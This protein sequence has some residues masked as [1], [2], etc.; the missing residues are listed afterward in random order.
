MHG[1]RKDMPLL[2]VS[3]GIEVSSDGLPT[4]IS[5]AHSQVEPAPMRPVVTSTALLSYVLYNAQDTATDSLMEKRRA[6]QRSKESVATGRQQVPSSG[7]GSTSTEEL[8]DLEGSAASRRRRWQICAA[9]GCRPTTRSR[10]T[11]AC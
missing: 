1:G 3:C 5:T 9:V 6:V 11:D 4:P 10:S 2:C 8:D 7:E